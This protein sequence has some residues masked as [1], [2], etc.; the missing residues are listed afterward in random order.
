MSRCDRRWDDVELLRSPT[1]HALRH[2]PSHAFERLSY[3]LLLVICR[4]YILHCSADASVVNGLMVNESQLLVILQNRNQEG[5]N[6]FSITDLLG[7]HI[8]SP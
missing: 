3:A 4:P 7:P 5:R 1:S 6:S 2:H 8:P